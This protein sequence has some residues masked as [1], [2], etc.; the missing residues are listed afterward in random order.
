MQARGCMK[1]T[2]DEHEL[3]EVEAELRRILVS[4]DLEWI[5]TSV[6]DAIRVGIP[7]EKGI[8]IRRARGWR[9]DEGHEEVAIVLRP[10]SR[11][12][13]Q[14]TVVTNEPFTAQQR[15]D[16]FLSSIRQAMVELPALQEDMLELLSGTAGH[17]SEGVSGVHFLPEV[18]TDTSVPPQLPELQDP[19]AVQ[20]RESALRV[21]DAL[22]VEVRI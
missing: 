2:M 11:E 3:A 4:A 21:L 18:D 14:R 20:R 19:E 8:V 9:R 10:G 5:L 16:L 17:E 15:V 7:S 13:P 6:Y 12:R 1:R 22:L